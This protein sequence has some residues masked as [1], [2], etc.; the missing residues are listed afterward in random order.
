MASRVSSVKSTIRATAFALSVA[1]GALT[2]SGCAQ[3]RDAQLQRV[4]RDWCQTIRASQVIPVYPLTQD[5]QPGDL[6]LVNR[7]VEEQFDSKELRSI[8]GF[9]PLDVH[10][11]RIDPN[12]Y[13]EFYKNSFPN[14]ANGT[15]ATDLITP[16]QAGK[17]PWTLGPAAA[18]PTYTISVRRGA[19]FSAA[20][21]ISGVPIGLS[22]LGTDSADVSVSI[23]NA[24]TIGVDL[25][26]LHTQVVS[27]SNGQDVAPILRGYATQH[28]DNPR[29]VRVIS[30]VYVTGKLTVGIQS[31]EAVSGALSAGVPKSIDLAQPVDATA[32]PG[33][34]TTA[35]RA[36]D[37]YKSS[38]QSLND[39]LGVATATDAL[40]GG[41]VKVLAFS[42]RSVAMSQEFTDTP[43]VIG[44]V[45]FDYPILGNGTLGRPVPTLVTS[46]PKEDAAAI[47]ELR[48]SLSTPVTSGTPGERSAANS[49]RLT[50][51]KIGPEFVASF[52]KALTEN[53]D[54][55]DPSKAAFNSALLDFLSVEPQ[56]TGPRHAIVRRAMEA[57]IGTQP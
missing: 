44:Y 8:R 24:H 55:R 20:L 45:G 10:L 54:S 12:G 19:G 51:E 5:L 42:A 56:G 36:I 16:P 11:A 6:F 28:A 35:E 13:K 27:W 23:E 2:L 1:A 4:A 46:N 32:P 43:L 9:M 31:T 22:L 33:T 25:I 26:S 52:E 47:I 29:Y 48:R 37:G 49:Y 18:F 38:L 40:P 14:L 15:L 21:P 17:L 7:N 57:S 41:T 50:A 30:R 34:I 53:Q 39:T 3:S